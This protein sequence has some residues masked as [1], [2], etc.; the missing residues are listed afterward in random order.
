MVWVW[1]VDLTRGGSTRCDER[2]TGS[3]PDAQVLR[4]GMYVGDRPSYPSASEVVR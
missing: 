3:R 2:A 4:V 1:M